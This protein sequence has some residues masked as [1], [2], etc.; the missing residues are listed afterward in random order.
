MLQICLIAAKHEC[1]VC[2]LIYTETTLCDDAADVCSAD[3]KQQRTQDTA[4]SPRA[5]RAAELNVRFNRFVV[6]VYEVYEVT[7][8]A[9]VIPRAARLY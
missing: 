7:R 2:I 1:V 4:G 6:E 9:S 3:H 5:R 8:Y